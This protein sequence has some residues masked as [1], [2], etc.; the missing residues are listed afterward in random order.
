VPI[1]ENKKAWEDWGVVDPLWAVLTEPGTRGGQWNLDDFFLSGRQVVDAALTEASRLGVP[2]EHRTG[3]DFGCGVGRLTRSLASQ[4]EHVVGLDIA[5]TM[6][7]E[8]RRLNAGIEG[9][10]FRVQRDDDLRAFADGS[11]DVVFTILVLQHI[12]SV[13]AIEVYLAEFVRV[14]APGG[15]LIFQLPTS[16]PVPPR[17]TM[18][19]Q[20]RPRTRL[21]VALRQAGVS[22]RWLNRR[23]G[24]SPA[25]PMTAIAHDRVISVLTEAGGTVLATNETPADHGGV[26]S[27]YYYVTH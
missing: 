20:L 4:V 7:A 26:E 11:I 24:W 21:A 13:A 3:L 14:L 18:R 8:A 17:P 19:S 9:C 25:M 23:L 12:P 16:V 22:P 15:V 1:P 5:D 6:I 10:E 27:R 2:A